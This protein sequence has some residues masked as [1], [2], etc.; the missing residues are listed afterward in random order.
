MDEVLVP[1]LSLLRGAPP[2][3]LFLKNPCKGSG[4]GED[5]PGSA[6]LWVT[7][8]RKCSLFP[9]ITQ[10]S[11]LGQMVVIFNCTGH[12]ETDFMKLVKYLWAFLEDCTKL[13]F[14]EDCQA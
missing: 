13:R 6:L 11:G 12:C 1:A 3:I 4:G 9:E 2:G 10:R 8:D 5:S 14:C 7:P